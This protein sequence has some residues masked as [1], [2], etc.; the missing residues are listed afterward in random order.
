M[1]V[2]HL[3][4][5]PDAVAPFEYSVVPSDRQHPEDLAVLHMRQTPRDRSP[6]WANK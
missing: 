3:A 4:R 5:A 1:P 2:A 6:Q